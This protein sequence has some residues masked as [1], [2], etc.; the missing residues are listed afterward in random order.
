MTWKTPDG[1]QYLNGAEAD[2]LRSTLGVMVDQILTNLDFPGDRLWTFDVQLFDELSSAQQLCL[3]QNVA[4]H[5]LTETH[6]TPDLN[7][8]NEAAVYAIYRALAIQI[9]IEV[10]TEK[11]G[12]AY[13]DD[14]E[15]IFF[16]R[17]SALVAH[18][19]AYPYATEVDS[20]DDNDWCVP[21]ATCKDMSQ[22]DFLVDSLA[23]RILFDRDFELAGTFL[24]AE[25][26]KAAALKQILGIKDDYYTDVSGDAN[27]DQI[28]KM[29]CSIRALS[30]QK[31]R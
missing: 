6:E 25:P 5:L 17:Q 9:E 28:E 12:T 26:A 29:I 15:S 7:A 30:R 19:Q 18:A 11:H 24:D 4:E 14:P 10:D 1:D 27:P 22:W 21:T 20:L 23:D 2:I 13:C 16:W 31:P 3:I 8:V